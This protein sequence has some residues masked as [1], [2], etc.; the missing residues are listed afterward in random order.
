MIKGK[1]YLIKKTP[2]W[3]K[4]SRGVDSI[5]IPKGTAQSGIKYM[6]MQGNTSSDTAG[7]VG[8][9]D[10]ERGKYVIKLHSHGKS[11]ISGENF[12]QLVIQSGASETN[13]KESSGYFFTK[14]LEATNG[15][16]V[17]DGR[18]IRFKENTQY[19]I[20]TTAK[21]SYS[22]SYRDLRLRFDY[23]DGSYYF[24]EVKKSQTQLQLCVCSEK[25]KT[26]RAISTHSTNTNGIRY[27]LTSFCIVEGAYETYAEASA[28]YSGEWAEILLDNP[29]RSFG[30]TR[31]EIDLIS[32]KL[33]RRV[34]K[35]TIDSDVSCAYTNDDTV[36]L[37]MLPQAMRPG[38][39]FSSPFPPMDAGEE[40]GI[41]ASGDGRY[42]YLKLPESI[43]ESGSITQYLR[44]NPFEM[45]YP[46]KY[47]ETEE[48]ELPVILRAADESVVEIFTSTPPAKMISVYK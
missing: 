4:L 13:K 30:Y 28:K 24:P 26:V 32:G 14:P 41:E 5:S 42:I 36:F 21:Y 38:C 6:K 16:V 45:V 8:D 1:A 35:V 11:F 25:G 44:D 37:I 39:S 46:L 47:P 29:L 18:H 7:S 27:L 3:Y 2:V 17:I 40:Y 31:D 12:M 43:L 48:T 34:G 22:A 19:T 33:T 20:A 15:S 9:F 10:E 23:T